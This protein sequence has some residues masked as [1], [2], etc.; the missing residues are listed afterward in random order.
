MRKIFILLTFLVTGIASAK[1]VTNSNEEIILYLN[2]NNECV[3]CLNPLKSFLQEYSDKS[4][5][6]IYVE[7]L[8][9]DYV[10]EFIQK[11]VFKNTELN[12][13][14]LS[15]KTIQEYNI[16]ESI[17]HRVYFL[18]SGKV[19]S[20]KSCVDF[21][22]QL[23][24]SQ[25]RQWKTGII[26]SFLIKGDMS[27]L[28]YKDLSAIRVKEDTYVLHGYGPKGSLELYNKTSG[29]HTDLFQPA[30]DQNI[31]KTL[32][33]AFYPKKL[34]QFCLNQRNDL[35]KKFGAISGKQDYLLENVRVLNNEIMVSYR[36]T[37]VT[38]DSSTTSTFVFMLY[39][40]KGKVKN[41]WLENYDPSIVK[42]YRIILSHMDW[43]YIND[44]EMA[45]PVYRIG[46]S[47]EYPTDSLFNLGIFRMTDNHKLELVRV[48]STTEPKE[49]MVLLGRVAYTWFSQRTVCIDDKDLR[50][51]RILY[52]ILP[53]IY[54][55]SNEIID[56]LH[57][58]NN[59][60]FSEEGMKRLNEQMRKEQFSLNYVNQAFE[61]NNGWGVIGYEWGDVSCAYYN[62]EW[63]LVSKSYFKN[64]GIEFQP[65]ICGDSLVYTKKYKED[66]VTHWYVYEIALDSILSN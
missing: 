43:Y 55:S 62:S 42:P 8:E 57:V 53:F 18:K 50:E 51:P 11:G 47:Q 54:N 40:L 27:S 63:E 38:P 58:K 19:I 37:L 9:K 1:P 6:Y 25:E 29:I 65:K 36:M 12:Y 45:L 59:Y 10:Q 24:L 21:I 22:Q 33:H 31:L 17:E 56:T 64:P 3:G 7:N 2:Y 39:D 14:I 35:I 49:K 46:I 15:K 41:Y 44:H 16:S 48:S 30:T 20:S 23:A 5:L 32:Y 61:H 26:D 52:S 13:T 66:G 28:A 34:A 60:F 4:S